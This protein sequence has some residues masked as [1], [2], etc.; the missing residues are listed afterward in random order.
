MPVFPAV[1]S[2]MVPPGLS[3]PSCS[4]RADDADGCPILY[5]AAWIQV[6]ELRENVRGTGWNQPFHPQHGSFTDKLSD[7]VGNAQ[8]G[9]F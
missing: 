8:A 1:A 7:V 6:F 2:T 3:L 4:A 5:A 9:H